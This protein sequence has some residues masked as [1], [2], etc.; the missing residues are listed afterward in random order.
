MLSEKIIDFRRP[1]AGSAKALAQRGILSATVG[2]HRGS[3][4]VGPGAK[5]VL[6]DHRSEPSIGTIS[7]EGAAAEPCRQS[8]GEAPE[9]AE[10]HLRWQDRDR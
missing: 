9:A 4:F 7:T 6:S 10:L 2:S 1:G 8:V 3:C 5:L